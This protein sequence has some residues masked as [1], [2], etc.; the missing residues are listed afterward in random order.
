MLTYPNIT[1]KITD[2]NGDDVGKY[3]PIETGLFKIDIY[4]NI[5][6]TKQEPIYA[7]DDQ[8]S[9]KIFDNNINLVKKEDGFGFLITT[10]PTDVIKVGEV[11]WK[12]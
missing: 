4:I 3:L 8:L 1:Y 5:S 6:T 7:F 2:L 10:Y 9:I 12:K 11:V